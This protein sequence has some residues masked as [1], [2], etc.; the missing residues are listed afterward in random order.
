MKHKHCELIK[1]WAEGADIEYKHSDRSDWER[2][3]NPIWN[4]M[5]EYRIKPKE[6][7]KIKMECWMVYSRLEWY[8]EGK[9]KPRE[10]QVRVPSEDKIIEVDYTYRSFNLGLPSSF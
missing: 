3:K 5:G 2:I 1:A 8:E 9:L 10:Y 4:G 6:T 7:K